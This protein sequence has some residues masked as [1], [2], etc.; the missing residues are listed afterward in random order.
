MGDNTQAERKRTYGKKFFDPRADQ[1]GLN[2]GYHS[3]N[4]KSDR[5][6]EGDRVREP[7]NTNPFG[8]VKRKGRGT[9]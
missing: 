3:T 2:A 6:T 8:T 9:N 7:Q 4:V 1:H 5:M